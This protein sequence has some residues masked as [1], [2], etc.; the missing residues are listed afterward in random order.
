MDNVVIVPAAA[1]QRGPEDSTFVYVIQPGH[2]STTQPA[3]VAGRDV[4]G[5]R[6]AAPPS[7]GRTSSPTTRPLEGTVALRNVVPGHQ[8]G[9]E[10]VIENGIKSGDI[11]V[12]DGLDKLQDGTSVTYRLAPLAAVAS[13]QPRG[14]A[15]STTRP[16][17][18]ANSAR[19]GG[20]S[21]RRGGE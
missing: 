1:V 15:G 21:G 16:A 13:T 19:P 14:R 20:R 5:P 18:P 4:A 7:P 6:G 9:D 10:I 3:E 11:V 17:N 2:K 12:T 8:E